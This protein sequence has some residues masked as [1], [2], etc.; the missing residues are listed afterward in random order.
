MAIAALLFVLGQACPG[1]GPWCG[2]DVPCRGRSHGRDAR[3]VERVEIEESLPGSLPADRA[4]ALWLVYPGF[5]PF[6][7]EVGAF[8][9]EVGTPGG[10]FELCLLPSVAARQRHPAV[11]PL[12]GGLA[13]LRFD[14][15]RRSEPRFPLD[16]AFDAG[17]KEGLLTARQLGSLDE[18][19]RVA[20][21]RAED[22]LRTW[23][24]LAQS[25]Y[26]AHSRRRLLDRIRGFDDP[27]PV[28]SKDDLRP[29][30]FFDRAQRSALRRLG[31]AIRGRCS[32]LFLDR[33]T[34]VELL[35]CPLS[36][37][38][39]AWNRRT[40]GKEALPD[41]RALPER[42]SEEIER[43]SLEL[44]GIPAETAARLVFG[45]LS[46]TEGLGVAAGTAH[47]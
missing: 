45:L 4:A 12:E 21:R 41:L 34:R 39:G 42:G 11:Q 6:P 30:R 16:P 29:E 28:C 40:A 36:Q 1:A 32:L 35:A 8:R 17:R 14:P 9:Y 38:A 2:V 43:L 18:L 5:E 7:A 47:P 46:A 19:Q 33:R 24:E 23:H 37:L 25:T 44:D 27:A 26:L 3:G 20:S 31:H 10:T 22:L 13:L 15:T